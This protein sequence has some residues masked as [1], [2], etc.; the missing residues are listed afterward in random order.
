MR[1]TQLKKRLADLSMLNLENI[2]ADRVSLG[3]VVKVMDL[4]TEEEQRYEL[5]VSEEADAA[6]G[7]VSTGSPIGRAL[8]GSR[9]GDEVNV[10]TPKGE[11]EL[12]VLD[13]KTIHERGAK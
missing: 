13:L 4:D 8:M 11:R 3:S 9:V 7:K 2:P 10:R 6:K 5:V 12:E 1:L